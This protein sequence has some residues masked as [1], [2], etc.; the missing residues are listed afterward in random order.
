M[1]LDER[2]KKY[3]YI[4]RQ[5]ALPRTPLII[6]VDGRAF[7]TLTKKFNKPFDLLFKHAMLAAAEGVI[8][9]L[10]GFKCAY[11]QSDEITFLL[12]DY[13][14]LN[15]QGWFNYNISKMISITSALASVHFNK[16]LLKNHETFYD[17]VQVFDSRAFNIP[18]EEVSN[19]FLW[20]AKDNYKNSVQTFARSLFSHKELHGKS[21]EDMLNMCREKG[22]PWEDIYD[23]YKNGAFYTNSSKIPNCSKL[24]FR[25]DIRPN[26]TDID[27]LIKP[28]ITFNKEIN[29][30]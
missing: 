10:Q 6:R 3:E 25:F 17:P 7:H 13:D 29:N 5:Y 24:I 16:Y 26:F 20:R 23:L 9:D 19:M 12:T 4:T 21:V 22:K 2:M 15:T 1:K 8:K 30:E 11:V 14:D 28:L 27:N 18:I